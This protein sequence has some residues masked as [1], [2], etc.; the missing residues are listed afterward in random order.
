MKE[1]VTKVIDTRNGV[2]FKVFGNCTG[3]PGSIPRR[4]IPKSWK[5][6][7]NVSVLYTQHH[8]VRIKGK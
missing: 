4:I 7:F 1:A 2:I 3:D 5:M 6:V 8:K